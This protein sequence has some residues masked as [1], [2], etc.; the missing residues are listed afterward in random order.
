MPYPK[1]APAWLTA[2]WA[3]QRKQATAARL[4]RPT[5]AELQEA[6]R[7]YR[8]PITRGKTVRAYGALTW[9]CGS[10]GWHGDCSA[11]GWTRRK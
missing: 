6:V 7:A 8:G 2:Q 9:R 1:T 11:D 3:A 10:A 5:R 4:P